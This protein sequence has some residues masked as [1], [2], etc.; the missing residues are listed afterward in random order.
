ML[1]LED[2]ATVRAHFQA[3]SFEDRVLKMDHVRIGKGASV[4]AGTVVL[5]GADIGDGARVGSNCVVMKNE[6]LLPG[7]DYA[8][9]P[10]APLGRDGGFSFPGSPDRAR[11]RTPCV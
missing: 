2:G 6:L 1:T 5:Y 10:A 7:R 4:G 3:H 11:A 9:A 8:G